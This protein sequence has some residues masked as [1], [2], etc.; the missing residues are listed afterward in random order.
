M[1]HQPT[2]RPGRLSMWQLS[3]NCS[4]RVVVRTVTSQ[5]SGWRLGLGFTRS[6]Q[7]HVYELFVLTHRGAF[8]ARACTVSD[9]EARDADTRGPRR[10]SV[11]ARHVPRRQTR[12]T[13][14]AVSAR[15]DSQV[16]WATDTD[17]THSRR[18]VRTARG[19][20]SDVRRHASRD[21]PT[22]RA[23]RSIHR[24]KKHDNR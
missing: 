24:I 5:L 7:L 6:L 21:R 2:R 13:G 4:P 12:R 10:A 9:G 19:V 20:S 17:S 18:R 14:R 15:R 3:G 11:T 16:R 22:D 1:I 8:D 23:V